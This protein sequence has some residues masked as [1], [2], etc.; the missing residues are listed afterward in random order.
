MIFPIVYIGAIVVSFL[1]VV[2]MSYIQRAGEAK[3]NQ[4]LAEKIKKK[5]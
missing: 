5:E 1:F 4:D 2:M 3:R